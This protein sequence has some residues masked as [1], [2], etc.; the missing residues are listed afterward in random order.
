MS[1]K[2]TETELR[3]FY[4]QWAAL[5]STFCRLYLGD[6]ELAENVV[7]QSFL[8]YFRGELPLQL[9]HLPTGLMSLTLEEC[10]RSGGQEVEVDSEFEAAVLG[11]TPEERAVFILHGVLD[12]QLP[13]VA[14][15]TGIAYTDVC[16]WWVRALVQLRMVIVRDSCSHL[17][18]ESALV[19][20]SLRGARA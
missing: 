19:P 15:V 4:D 7:A 2:R 6:A 10:D 1:G 11:L 12:L 8:Q 9:D 17:F 5:V 20:E 3:Q 13:W 14:A 18:A 16:Q